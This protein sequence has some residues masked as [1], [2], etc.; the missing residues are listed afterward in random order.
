MLPV[1][2]IRHQ[3]RRKLLA[4]SG[5]F[6]NESMHHMLR[7]YKTTPQIGSEWLLSGLPDTHW[8]NVP[9]YW[10]EW[11]KMR[12]EEGWIQ[13]ADYVTELAKWAFRNRCFLRAES[14]A[15]V[16]PPFDHIRHSTKWPT[17]RNSFP[18]VNRSMYYLWAVSRSRRIILDDDQV[19]KI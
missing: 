11:M 4:Q 3:K 17:K 9:F 7:I 2:A 1:A 15:P 14:I 10:Q 12:T 5:I 19:G 6:L 13:P 8:W 18:H 16:L